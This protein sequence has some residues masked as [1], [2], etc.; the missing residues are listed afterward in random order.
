M[1]TCQR[2]LRHSLAA[3]G[4]VQSSSELFL[5]PL[6]SWLHAT[7][8]YMAACNTA[9]QAHALSV[10]L[11]QLPPTTN[12]AEADPQPRWVV[13]VYAHATTGRGYTANS[14]DRSLQVNSR[15]CAWHDRQ[16]MARPT[17]HGT[18]D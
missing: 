7:I 9:A 14:H 15:S 6:C 13:V 1:A 18:T 11:R 4:S 2:P 17:V 12:S 5:A 8:M 3:A 10:V 16:C